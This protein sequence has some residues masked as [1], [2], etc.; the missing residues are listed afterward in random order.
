M[1][2]VTKLTTLPRSVVNRIAIN[3]MNAIPTIV[4]SVVSTFFDIE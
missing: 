4:P 3:I 1:M 2:F